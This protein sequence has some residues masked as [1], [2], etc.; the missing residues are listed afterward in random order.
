MRAIGLLC[1]RATEIWGVS[2]LALKGP[3]RGR[4]DAWPRQAVMYVA[5]KE[6]G[7]SVTVIGRALGDRDPSTVTHACRAVLDR[8]EKYAQYRAEVK[9]LATYSREIPASASLSETNGVRDV[10]GALERAAVDAVEQLLDLSV[11][12]PDAFRALI[13]DVMRRGTSGGLKMRAAE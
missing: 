10:R 4:D 6:M 13:E 12:N 5:A 11:A 2:V 9:A 7:L 1:L 8:V 3:R